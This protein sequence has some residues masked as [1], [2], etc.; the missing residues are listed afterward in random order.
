VLGEGRID[1][2]VPQGLGGEA[3]LKV[4]LVGEDE[5]KPEAS[6]AVIETVPPLAVVRRRADRLVAD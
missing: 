2:A 5:P 3:T 1:H 4:V 6:E